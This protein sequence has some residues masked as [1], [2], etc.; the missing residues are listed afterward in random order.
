M[1][2]RIRERS[3]SRSRSRA[4][5]PARPRLIHLEQDPVPPWRQTPP[6]WRQTPPPG[7]TPPWRQTPPLERPN[8]STLDASLLVAALRSSSLT[9]TPAPPGPI[10]WHGIPVPA[11]HPLFGC[12]YSVP[13][14]RVRCRACGSTYL[15]CDARTF[16]LFCC[17]CNTMPW[18]QPPTLQY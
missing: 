13:D 8:A 15:T 10:T 9:P 3:R 5:P 17:R 14:E 16:R 4:G 7:P 6:P 11:H 2:S 12:F 18:L 1:G